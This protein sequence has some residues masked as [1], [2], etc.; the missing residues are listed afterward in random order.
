MTDGGR[1]RAVVPNAPNHGCYGAWPGD[2]A[3]PFAYRLL[4]TRWRGAGSMGGRRLQHDRADARYA[5]KVRVEGQ[6]RRADMDGRGRDPEVVG[7]HRTTLGSEIGEHLGV[8]A[9]DVP[10]SRHDFHGGMGEEFV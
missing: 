6:E 10:V 2:D 4:R 1:L 9:G 7:R 5:S 3:A 8:D